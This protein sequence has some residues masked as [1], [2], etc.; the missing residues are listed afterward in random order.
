MGGKVVRAAL[1]VAF[2]LFFLF[3]LYA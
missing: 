2:G 1:W 3:P